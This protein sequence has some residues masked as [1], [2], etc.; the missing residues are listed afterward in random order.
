MKFMPGL[1]LCERF[2]RDA[3]SPI[4]E[5]HFPG[6]VHSAG[7]LG[8]GSDV[9]GFD[10]PTSMDHHWGPRVTLFLKGDDFDRYGES[11][12][13]VM[14][15]ELPYEVCGI[16][17]NFCHQEARFGQLKAIE[18]G[19]VSHG[20]SV[21]TTKAFFEGYIGI[22]ALD[23]LSALD[24]LLIPHQLLRTIASGRVFHDGLGELGPAREVL[25]WYP[26][27]VWLYLLACQWRRID[28][29]EPFMA[30]CD[31]V[32]DELG[33]RLVAS[34]MINELMRLCFLMERQYAPYYKWFGT[35]FSR[36]ECASILTPIFQSIFDSR[37]WR[38]REQHLSTAYIQVAKMHNALSLTPHIEPELSNFHSRPYMV[39]HSE[40]FVDALHGQIESEEVRLLPKHIGAVWQFA[41]STD[42]LDRLNRCRQLRVLYR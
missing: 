24:W 25:A 10:T 2:Y 30:R 39:L 36:L 35:A 33:S 1:D 4:L 6:L 21:T 15:R 19:P 7:R 32:G 3:V 22:N 8:R 13:E 34:R 5:R 12:P 27:D 14:S 16:P 38:E 28:Q 31:D 26:H 29:E 9:L 37:N 18:S 11:I 42:V 40:R 20:V 23:G 41:D 17:T